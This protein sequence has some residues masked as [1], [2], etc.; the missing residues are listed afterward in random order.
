M[1]QKVHSLVYCSLSNVQVF[2]TEFCQ[3]KARVIVQGFVILFIFWFSVKMPYK[4]SLISLILLL[5]MS[6]LLV[7]RIHWSN[8]FSSIEEPQIRRKMLREGSQKKKLR[9]LRHMPNR[10]QVG[11]VDAIFFSE[12][13]FGQFLE[14]RQVRQECSY[15]FQIILVVFWSIIVVLKPQF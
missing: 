11:S 1:L 6:S 10:T 7:F 12:K 14:G 8:N 5:N 2:Y 9:N 13:K 3:K 15:F 4:G